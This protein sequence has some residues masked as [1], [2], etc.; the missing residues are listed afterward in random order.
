MYAAIVVAISI[1]CKSDILC[2]HLYNIVK[3]Q[4]CCKVT[5]NPPQKDLCLKMYNFGK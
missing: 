4:R 3:C 2:M 1:K 5:A